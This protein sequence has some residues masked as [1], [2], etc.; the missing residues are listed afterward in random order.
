MTFIPDAQIEAG[1]AELWRHHHLAPNFN[2]EL[3]LDRLRL[4]LLWDP[5]PPNVLGALQAE[6]HLVILNQDRLP[7]FEAKP[8]LERF[9]VAHEVGHDILHGGDSW[10]GVLPLMENGK[11][12]CRD[13][14]RTA[15]EFQANRF[16]SYL[17]MPTD[18]LRPMLPASPWGGWPEIYRLAEAFG[19]TPTAMLVRLRN[20]G[21]VHQATDGTPVSGPPADADASSTT[22]PGL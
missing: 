16:A 3:L 19:V 6:E 22:L 10:T 9:T 17:L 2:I 4:S 1:A 21:Y 5:L 18:Q 12:W 11:T 7:D 14:S 20:G 15:T 8:G 13:D